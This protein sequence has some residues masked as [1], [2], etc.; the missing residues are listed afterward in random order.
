MLPR[1]HFST[2]AVTTGTS[3][4]TRSFTAD[5]A[6][7]TATRVDNGVSQTLAWDPEGHLSKVTGSSTVAEFLYDSEGNRM[8]RRQGGK[9]TLYLG[10]TE[11]TVT[12]STG[13]VTAQ[14]YYS[15]AGR[16]VAVRKGGSNADVS[17]LFSN[18]QNTALHSVV[19]T[20]STLTVRRSTPYG[21]TRGPGVSWN[22]DHGFLDGPSDSA[23]GLTHLG[24][25]EYDPSL[26]R[27]LSVDP[28]IDVQDPLQMNAYTYGQN[29]P[30][31]MSDP[32]GRRPLGAGDSA[33]TNCKLT[34]KKSSS[35]KT[36]RSWSY[37]NESHGSRSVY[38]S[39]SRS[40][41][42]TGG[43]N[44]RPYVR[45]TIN[46]QISRKRTQWAAI[47]AGAN[48]AL[49]SGDFATQL[50]QSQSTSH[51]GTHRFYGRHGVASYEGDLATNA[52]LGKLATKGAWV[53]APF[54]GALEAE[55]ERRDVLQ[56][57]AT[58]EQADDVANATFAA[59][60]ATGLTAGAV[61]AGV[62]TF[63]FP[64]VGTVAGAAIGF[65]VGW[66]F[67]A[68]AQ[69]FYQPAI[70]NHYGVPNG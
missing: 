22:G 25:R 55:Q 28:V 43:R 45:E 38:G 1:P 16:T 34:T 66:A 49:K 37:R 68:L 63:L 47:T 26:G 4:R 10:P 11:L 30:V 52:R 54:G 6:G 40:Y 5:G 42:Y 61:G 53:L 12:T 48:A 60:T 21:G 41:K 65:G 36:T 67:S 32:D 9:T 39:R 19:N 33:C 17:T 27:F 62:G 20:T 57:G 24:A 70:R 8:T 35:G 58:D 64:G 44:Y 15:F 51:V 59:A 7:N 3:S 50:A 46:D 18:P 23:T 31:A 14:R 2:T 69:S 29:N 56:L 13:V